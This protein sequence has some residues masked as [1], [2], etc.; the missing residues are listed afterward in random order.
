MP[1]GLLDIR[2]RPQD[3]A[4]LRRPPCALVFLNDESRFQM[5]TGCLEVS[6]LLSPI[7]ERFVD[8]PNTGLVVPP[9]LLFDGES[10]LQSTA[11][12]LQIP[13]ISE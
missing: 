13:E 6:L 10:T 12:E 3:D 7:S 4:H 11:R 5:I 9:V 2:E 8:Y 1:H